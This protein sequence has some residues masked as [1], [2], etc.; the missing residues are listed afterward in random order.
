[1]GLALASEMGNWSW[2]EKL[3]KNGLIK[4]GL[5]E[6]KAISPPFQLYVVILRFS[7]PLHGRRVPPLSSSSAGV[8]PIYPLTTPTSIMPRPNS[9]STLTVTKVTKR[10]SYNS[11]DSI[12]SGLTHDLIFNPMNGVVDV[13]PDHS[14]SGHHS[15]YVL[16][17]GTIEAR[18]YF[19]QSREY[20]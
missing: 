20:R 14:D 19:I 1:M 2:E 5:G 15:D 7:F 18:D 11:F 12:P 4:A 10:T 3:K 8:L 16:Y 13:I 17:T 9:D 6:S